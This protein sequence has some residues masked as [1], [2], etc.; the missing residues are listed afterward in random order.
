MAAALYYLADKGRMQKVANSFGIGKS[1]VSKVIRRVTQAILKYLGSKYIV[2]P[3]NEKTEEMASIYNSHGFPQCIG[4][5]DGTH[6]R[7]KRP[8][9]NASDFIKRKGKLNIQAAVDYNYCFLTW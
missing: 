2:L 5:V 4:A 1:T 6:V 3:T 7:V 8:S 9:L